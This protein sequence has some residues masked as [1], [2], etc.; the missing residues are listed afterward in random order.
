MDFWEGLC[1]EAVLELVWSGEQVARAFQ[2]E[3]TECVWAGSE[4]DWSS[5][6]SVWWETRSPG[7]P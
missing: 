7:A 2:A 6:V 3:A 4:A 5:S 1:K